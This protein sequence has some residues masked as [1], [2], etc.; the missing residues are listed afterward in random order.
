VL[1]PVSSFHPSPTSSRHLRHIRTD[2]CVY[3]LSRRFE[4]AADR[5]SVEYTQ[6]PK[7]AIH[8][9]ANLYRFTQAPTYCDRVTELF[10]THPAFVR[11]A[12]AIGEV[13]RMP[14]EQLCEIVNESK[15]REVAE[16]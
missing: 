8:A 5:A 12:E 10:M 4:Y 3:F 1:L 14:A 9:L 13:G 2:S 7:A 16:T 11:R 15:V 6:D